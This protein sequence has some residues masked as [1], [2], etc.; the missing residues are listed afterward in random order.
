[1]IKY[2]QAVS[3]GG[4]FFHMTESESEIWN[5]RM[6][7]RK[8]CCKLQSFLFRAR[9]WAYITKFDGQKVTRNDLSFKAGRHTLLSF[10]A[11]F[12]LNKF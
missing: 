3:T 2:A 10:E 9:I 11:R 12:A 5:W 1:M 4:H 6:Y 8:K 7:R